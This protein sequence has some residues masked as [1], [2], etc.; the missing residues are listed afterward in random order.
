VED[1]SE[2]IRRLQGCINDPISVL[3]LPALWNGRESSQ[4]VSTLLDGLLGM[5][6]LEFAYARLSDVIDGASVEMVRSPHRQ[7]QE[8]QPQE[9]GRALNRWLAGNSPASPQVTPNPGG[10]GEVS[11]ASFRLGLQHEIGV[12]VAG[13]HRADFPTQIEMLLLRVAANQAAIGLQEARRLNE[14]RRA[15]SNETAWHCTRGLNW[16]HCASVITH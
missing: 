6:R 14:R 13:S 8:V 11:L 4:I 3:A 5:L 7:N 10:E 2:E 16:P 1:R 12:L 9:V 15:P